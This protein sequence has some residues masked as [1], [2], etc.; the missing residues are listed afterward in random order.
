V[1]GLEIA[2]CPLTDRMD[3]AANLELAP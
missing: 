3:G 2:E 1:G